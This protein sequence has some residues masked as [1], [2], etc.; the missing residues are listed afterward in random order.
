M[1]PSDAP[2]GLLAAWLLTYAIHSTILLGTAWIV[3][4]FAR[5][6][7]ALRDV[8]WKTALLGALVTASW[9]VALPGVGPAAGRW[10]L[11][12][13][14]VAAAAAPSYRLVPGGFVVN[15]DG[16][17][18]ARGGV[19]AEASRTG[20]IEVPAARDRASAAVHA[21]WRA[22]SPFLPLVLVLLWILGAGLSIFRL[23]LAK[24]RL[25]HLLRG[26]RP[27]SGGPLPERLDRLRRSAGIRR[28]VR[29]TVSE[30]IPGPVALGRSEICLP[31]RA[32]TDLDPVHQE[33]VLAHELGHLARRDPAWLVATATIEAIFFFQPLNRLARRSLRE[34]AE[35]LCD[36]WAVTHTGRSL[37]L[38]R[39]L[40]EV[41]GWIHAPAR[42]ALASAMAEGGSPLV[43]R[44]ERL[45]EE[46]PR[47]AD[48]LRGWTWAGVGAMVALT[49]AIAPGVTAGRRAPVIVP[50]QASV[51]PAAVV[52]FQPAVSV[53]VEPSAPPRVLFIP[54]P[55]PAGDAAPAVGA[56]PRAVFL[57]L[58]RGRTRLEA[59]IPPGR[60]L[61]ISPDEPEPHR[62]LARP[63]PVSAGTWMVRLGDHV[64]I[65]LD[66]LLTALAD[67]PEAQA[68]MNALQDELRGRL[69]SNME[70]LDRFCRE[71]LGPE[72][73]QL[74]RELDP[75]TRAQLLDLKA[76]L[77]REEA[78]LHSERRQALREDARRTEAAARAAREARMRARTSRSTI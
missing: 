67:S 12:H 30:R 7:L 65:D 33:S 43:R 10:S 51:F 39:C 62:S 71:R 31:G 4:R 22:I 26:R 61:T 25:H 9:Q 68:R 60:A 29:L 36:D 18:D 50:P 47:R 35:F 17:E 23:G 74:N 41:A 24:V 49:A 70:D 32:L 73:E 42:P 59:P 28:P 54:G 5:T 40:A 8:L 2:G 37:T 45:L 76:R 75:A 13:R 38:A 11:P 69:G 64:Q 72:L 15:T 66:P 16:P 53:S 3:T 46:G 55:P 1:T 6:R 14:A 48:R 20:A 58:L 57:P 77:I 63:A 21:G 19:S 52:A 56:A 27:L 44:I 34:T 78:R